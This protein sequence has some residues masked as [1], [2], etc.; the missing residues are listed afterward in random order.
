MTVL[1]KREP[2]ASAEPTKAALLRGEL[3][4]PKLSFLMEAHNG[5]SAK[6]VEEAGFRG[7]WASGLSISAALGVRD[8]NEASWT[9]VLEILEFMSDATSIPILVDGD[10]G[11]GNFNNVRRLVTKL[12][13]RNV[14]GVCIEDKLFPKT[15]SFL[16]E[17]QP[18]ADIDEFCGKIKAGKD[19]QL[20]PDFCVIARIEAFIA[21]WGLDEA[22]RRAEAYH[23]AGADAL[24]V[25]SK[26]KTAD[27]I[28]AFM[29]EWGNTCPVIIVPT[30]YYATP[31]E[32]FENAGISTVIWA[33]HNLRAAISGM[34][35]VCKQIHE[36]QSLVNVEDT[37]ASV[38]DVFSLAG[39]TELAEAERRYLPQ[40]DESAHA[41]ILAAT[42][43]DSLGPLT[44]DRP[45][46]MIDVRGKPL[47][48]TMISTLREGGIRNVT[49]VSGYRK[50]AIDIPAIDIR[51][52]ANFA[53]TG[54]VASLSCAIDRLKDGT[55]LI[56]YGDILYR[57]YILERLQE[58]DADITVVA[59]ALWR[60]RQ[61][62]KH[63][64]DFVQCDHPFH[65]DYLEGDTARLCRIGT[66]IPPEGIH[67]EWVG[68]VLLSPNGAKVVRDEIEVMST[69]GSL[70]KAD[71]PDLFN[72]L[73]ESGHKIQ[74]QYITG[75]WLDIDDPFDLAKARNFL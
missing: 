8:N 60:E 19:S 7:I 67:G 14:A 37:V 40:K 12:C 21:G 5:L 57:S 51:T 13:Q 3:R 46:C 32:Q 34:R 38:K 41:I 36:S 4:S 66:E 48:R 52:N 9:Q 50:E 20:D 74:V 70:Q 23:E 25:H 27:E 61:T 18:L 2:E 58:S 55:C 22:L 72:R 47:L 56:T 63:V 39:Q 45:K 43:G 53:E 30:M 15:N 65:P 28:F 73:V 31:T 64:R 24:L 6:I 1:P 69:D 11:Y 17:G 54:E 29:K 49:V 10:T 42:R 75:H 33:N 44:E 62:Q 16:G 71:M 35:D 59:D 26:E 68:L